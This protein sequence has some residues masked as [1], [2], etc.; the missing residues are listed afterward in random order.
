MP[1][2]KFVSMAC[3]PMSQNVVKCKNGICICLCVHMC[4]HVPVINLISLACMQNVN[5]FLKICNF[6]IIDRGIIFALWVAP[7]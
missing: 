6:K 3:M 4:D 2:I 7:L 1:N 5:F